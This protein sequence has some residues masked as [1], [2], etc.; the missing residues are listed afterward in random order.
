MWAR[1]RDPGSYQALQYFLT[2]A[3]WSADALWRQL[4][5]ALPVR[6][7]I[8]MLDGTGFPRQGGASVGVGRPYPRTLGKITTNPAPEVLAIP[9]NSPPKCFMH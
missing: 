6:S 2:D 9:T 1:V 7:G 3:A 8:L 4:R 5:A